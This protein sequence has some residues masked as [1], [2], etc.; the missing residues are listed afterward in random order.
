VRSTTNTGTVNNPSNL[1]AGDL[2]FVISSTWR[3]GGLDSGVLTTPIFLNNNGW[4]WTRFDESSGQ[5]SSTAIWKIAES[6]DVGS[7]TSWSTS[8]GS[9][10]FAVAVK[11]PYPQKWLAVEDVMATEWTGS[12]Q[13]DMKLSCSYGKNRL[14]IAVLRSRRP[15]DTLTVPT[16]W[17]LLDSASFNGVYDATSYVIYR[18]VDAV[19]Y[20]ATQSYSWATGDNGGGCVCFTIR[21]DGDWTT[22]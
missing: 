15:N 2:L 1:A 11:N 14:Q 9:H 21:P 19:S 7:S 10:L 4:V 5:G 20:G 18:T 13:S 17:T 3:G 6:A 8:Y 16:G 22:V 12:D